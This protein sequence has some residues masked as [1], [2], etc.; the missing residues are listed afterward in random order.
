MNSQGNKGSKFS[1]YWR[2][3]RADKPIGTYLLLWP[4]LWGLIVAAEGMPPLHILFVFVAGVFVMRAAGCVIN[5]FADRK[6]DG[7]VK[8]TNSRPLVTGE[9]SSKEALSLFATLV[10]LAFGLVLTLN[11]QTIA[12]SVG[13][14]ALAACYPFMKRVTYLPQFVLGAAFSW[15][16]VM[17]FMAITETIPWWGWAIYFANLLWTVAYDTM[18]AMVDR[19]DDLEIGVKSTAIL[20]GEHDRTIILLL[21][22]ATLGVLFYTFEAINLGI[23]AQSSLAV[24]ALFF[25]YQ[26]RLIRERERDKCFKA[27]LNNNYVGLVITIG[28]AIDYLSGSFQF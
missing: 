24:S 21:Q 14:L 15:G 13:G 17:A 20:F 10:L 8:R 6:V 12:L 5:D 16:I 26:Q 23:A 11:W 22:V 3:M 1:G 7:K 2:L 28:I 4:T 18:Y 19:D 25:A 27:F 9:I